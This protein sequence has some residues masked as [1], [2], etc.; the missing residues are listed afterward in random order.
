MKV[1]V[2]TVLV[3]EEKKRVKFSVI[4]T[5]GEEEVVIGDSVL[6]FDKTVSDDEIK[7]QITEAAKK[8]VTFYE[9]AKKSKEALGEFEIQ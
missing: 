6:E 3:D 9:E 5:S 1:R 2:D 7:A 8:I 4:D